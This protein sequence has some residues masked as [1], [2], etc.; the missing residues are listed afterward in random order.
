MSAMSSS[1]GHA[2]RV[3]HGFFDLLH[4]SQGPE[5]A[6]RGSG[7]PA[8]AR[9]LLECQVMAQLFVQLAL[10]AI[11]EDERLEAFEDIGERVHASP[12]ASRNWRIALIVS[13]ARR[14]SDASVS[15]CR[16]P[17]RVRL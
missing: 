15:S 12:S 6:R 11:A 14:Q 17:A 5:G 8:R 13:A 1:S 4:A 7:L 16:R 10:Q 9:F 2:P 3:A